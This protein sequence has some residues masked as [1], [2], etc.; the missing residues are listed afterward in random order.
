MASGAVMRPMSPPPSAGPAVWAIVRE[1]SSLP[2]PSTSW[3]R[4]TRAGRYDW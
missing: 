4:S 3:S 1:I 2:L